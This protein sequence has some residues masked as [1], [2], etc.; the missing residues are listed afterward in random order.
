MNKK[1]L[2][3][4]LFVFSCSLLPAA[5]FGL[6]LD[7]NADYGG[8]GNRN[9]FTYSGIL[10]P[11]LSIML[12]NIGDV[13]FSAGIEASYNEKWSYVPELLRTEISLFQG[14]LDF[15]IGRMHY[16]EPL[17]FIAEG[18]FDGAQFSITGESGK[19]SLGVWYTGFLYKRR[20]NIAMTQEE[21]QSYAVSLDYNDFLSTYFA[22]RRAV[23]AL[24]WEYLGWPAQLR[25]FALGQVDLSNGFNFSGSPL[26]HTQYIAGKVSA[27][28]NVFSFDLGITLETIQDDG[29]F[30]MAYAAEFRAA[31]M[32]P[33]DIPNRLSFLAR[34]SSGKSKNSPFLAFQPI[35]TKGHG[36]IINAKFSGLSILSLDFMLRPHK[37]FSLGI[38]S[39]YF[40]RS[41]LETYMLYPVSEQNNSG[42]LLGD[43]FFGK[44]LWNPV[45]DIS[46]NFGGGVFLPFLG[47]VAPSADSSWRA[48]LNAVIS[49][50]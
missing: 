17:G 31:I 26:L 43:E 36:E 39:S 23:Y 25:L 13:F 45:S 37:T 24:N 42:Y 15:T 8:F 44:F 1:A 35:T 47:N 34:Y 4:F 5:D 9:T 22:P 27:P 29:K 10:T 6:V 2:V 11:R 28:G 21:L 19:L 16:Y 3:I 20:A 40:I 49:L 48:E 33:A 41:D 38:T 12:G 32:P 46:F 50:R 14:I 7:Q 18:L 30:G